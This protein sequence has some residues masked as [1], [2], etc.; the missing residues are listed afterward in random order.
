LAGAG[1][2]A[3]VFAGTAGA[4][5]AFDWHAPWADEAA[6]AVTYT[7]PSGA[8]CTGIV[9]NVTGP[10]DAVAAANEF[11]GRD[12]LL[13]VIDIDAA[14]T[15]LRSTPDAHRLSN[16]QVVDAG[17]GTEYWTADF[18]YEHA[19]DMAVS[20]ALWDALRAQGFTPEGMS[21][22]GVLNCPDADLPAWMGQ[23]GD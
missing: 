12:D 17:P 5:A 19:L 1:A 3:L 4:S 11:L 8:V 6:A 21:Y 16:G 2:L 13:D 7:L 22:E 14:I 23:A 20:T 9:G 18:E 10:P 15:Y